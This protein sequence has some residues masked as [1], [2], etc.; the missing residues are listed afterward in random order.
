M[1]TAKAKAHHLAVIGSN[2]TKAYHK[3]LNVNAFRKWMQGMESQLGKAL[4]M[5]CD[6]AQEFIIW[7]DISQ[8]RQQALADAVKMQEHQLDSLQMT[9]AAIAALC[10][11]GLVCMVLCW[12][13]I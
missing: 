8:K 10:V 7:H 2:S 11:V 3:R 1:A 13:W 4:S 5:A 12:P 9:S 6:V